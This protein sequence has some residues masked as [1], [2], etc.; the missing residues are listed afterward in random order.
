MR[1][2][3]PTAT[4]PRLVVRPPCRARPPRTSSDPLNALV[5]SA[6]LDWQRGRGTA[7]VRRASRQ[8]DR[9]RRAADHHRDA[10]RE[11]R[12]RPR[13]LD[14]VRRKVRSQRLGAAGEGAPRRPG[15]RPPK[16][17]C[18][19]SLPRCRALIHDRLLRSLCAAMAAT[20]RTNCLRRRAGCAGRAQ[21]R[22]DA[23]AAPVG[24][25]G[26]RSRCGSHGV[27]LRGV[28]LR[29][30]RVARGGIR[31]SDRPDDFRAEVLGLMRTQV[32]KNAVI[33]PVG[34][35]GGFVVTR[36]RAARPPIRR[37]SKP[38]TA[39]SSTRCCRSPTTS[40]AA[41]P[42]RRRAVSSSTTSPIPT[43]SSPPTRARRRSPTSPTSSPRGAASGSA[44]PSPRAAATATTT[45][46]LGITARGAWE[47]ARQHF[48]EIG[49]DLDRDAVTRRRHRRHERRRVRQRP[50]ALAPPA[51]ARRLQ[52]SPHLPRPAIPTPSASYRERAAALH[53]AALELGRLHAGGLEPGGGVYPRDAKSIPLSP[54]ARALLELDDRGTRRARRSCAPSCACRSTCCG[55]AASAPTS[56]RATSRI[57]DVADP[58]NDAVRI[59]ARELRATV[60]AEGGNL[61]LTQRARIEYA[62]SGG[63]I[64]TDAIDNSGGVDCSDHEVNLKIALQPLVAGGEPRRRG[65]QRAARRA[66]RARLRCG[67]RAQPRPGARAGPRSDALAHAAWRCSAT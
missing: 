36:R 44:T 8:P 40:S 52:P 65:A 51:S 61:G 55:T 57:V 5:V 49:R 26:R 7:R 4:A 60:V 46:A 64:N 37:G 43:S 22:P 53:P 23:T 39:P 27:G 18:A 41:Q 2:S 67:A 19:K 13:A 63:H 14:A 15:R 47:C 66:G 54:E 12:L 38:R 28:H 1:R 20:V 33:V 17:R 29:A 35:K 58:A 48:R 25:A 62:L 11:S 50:A 30:G 42:S 45:S 9:R 10:E 32:V 24:V 6:G 34:A 59:D 21:A 31:F 56:R 16:R 3:M